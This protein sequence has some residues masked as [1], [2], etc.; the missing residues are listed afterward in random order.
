MISPA[1]R[2]SPAE[3]GPLVLHGRR[4]R[5]EIS[6]EDTS[7][8]ADEVWR[9]EGAILQRHAMALI[10]DFTTLPPRYRQAVKD[11]CY[12]MLSGPLPPG[13]KRT[14]IASVHRVFG[15]LKRFL[16]W[17][18]SY[19][20]G[21][22]RPAGPDLADLRAQDLERYQL[23][24]LATVPEPGTRYAA[25]RAVRF[26]WRYR[27]GLPGDRLALDP[28][29]VDGWGEPSRPR[30]PPT[31]SPKP[32]S[33]RSSSGRCGSSTTSARTSW[34]QKTTAGCS[35]PAGGPTRPA[36]APGPARRCSDFSSSTCAR[37]AP[38]PGIGAGPT[39]A[40]SPWSWAATSAP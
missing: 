3:P 40:S 39:W 17:L 29:H 7:R 2:L 24:L 20:P 1:A 28:R 6:L 27:H 26:F 16:A 11:L 9:L 32:S 23:H 22:G 12:A 21:P 36:T 13:E 18:D 34:P 38:S 10:L 31:G 8:F 30:T 37:A 33:A 25:R 4:L 15:D 5:P 35:T 19:V 14:G